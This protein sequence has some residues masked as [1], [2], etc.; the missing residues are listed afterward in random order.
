V[1][2]RASK[3]NGL[4]VDSIIKVDKIA[5][6]QKKIILGELGAAEPDVVKTVNAALRKIFAL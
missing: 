4:K 6:L 1:A 2:I 5:T 3:E